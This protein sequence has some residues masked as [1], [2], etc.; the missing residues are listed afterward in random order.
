MD[1]FYD[2]QDSYIYIK[3]LANQSNLKD[4]KQYDRMEKNRRYGNVK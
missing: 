4:I 2:L 3:L 1:T